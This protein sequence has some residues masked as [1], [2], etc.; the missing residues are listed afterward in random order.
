MMNIEDIKNYIQDNATDIDK[1]KGVFPD[2][3]VVEK[4]YDDRAHVTY[5]YRLEKC[6]KNPFKRW[7]YLGLGK[8]KEHN[9][10]CKNTPFDRYRKE[11]FYKWRKRIERKGV[12][13]KRPYFSDYT[14]HICNYR[15]FKHYKYHYSSIW[16]RIKYGLF[17]YTPHTSLWDMSD[18]M[19][20]LIVK[21]TIMG[22]YHGGGFSH[23]L[24][25]KQ[26]M[27]TIWI[28]RKMLIEAMASEDIYNYAKDCEFQQHFHI[29]ECF[30]NLHEN[31]NKKE[32]IENGKII[33][34]WESGFNFGICPDKAEIK[35]LFDP[36][37][38][39]TKEGR[40]FIIKKCESMEKYY[41]DIDS[42]WYNI[43]G[44]SEYPAL[45]VF[46]NIK[47]RKAFEYISENYFEWGD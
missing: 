45:S 39:N 12:D 9:V 41:D 19:D 30:F 22:V 25:N 15:V 14:K 6:G 44:K 32:F 18:L 34:D 43:C 27:H 7:F 40:E 24:Y 38:Y 10:Y 47:I 21:L 28:A 5:L 17:E 11:A 13:I 31:F 26:K 37:L 35:A 23:V 3:P 8:D 20:Y 4:Q 16:K 33:S 29:K 1:P 46:M 2:T 42:D 36:N